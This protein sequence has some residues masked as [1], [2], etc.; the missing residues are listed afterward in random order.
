M[1]AEEEKIRKIENMVRAEHHNKDPFEL[2]IAG[3]FNHFDP[4]WDFNL[5]K[6]SGPTRA[7]SE[8][9]VFWIDNRWDISIL[10]PLGHLDNFESDRN[11][12]M[13]GKRFPK[14]ER[15]KIKITKRPLPDVAFRIIGDKLESLNV[16]IPNDVDKA[17]EKIRNAVQSIID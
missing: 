17:E 14:K 12:I 8:L 7:S 10:P 2:I 11:I 6:H 9:D 15:I 1:G 13:V 16:A 4:D 3:D 5:V